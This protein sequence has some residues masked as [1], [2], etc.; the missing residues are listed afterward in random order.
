MCAAAKAMIKL[1]GRAYRKT[2]RF[3]VMKGTQTHE[4]CA[5]FLELNVLA[6]DIDYVNTG[7]QI[8]NEGLGNQLIEFRKHTRVQPNC[9]SSK[10]IN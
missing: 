7:E 5:T 3:L 1:L 9:S 6:H 4:V 8:L 10:T 2:G